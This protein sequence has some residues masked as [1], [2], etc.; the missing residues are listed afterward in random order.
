MEEKLTLNLQTT[1]ST[2]NEQ[3]K[4][5]LNNCVYVTKRSM[6]RIENIGRRQVFR[7]LNEMGIASA[8]FI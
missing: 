6:C 2:H 7:L 8:T 4:I 3:L 1:F 5:L